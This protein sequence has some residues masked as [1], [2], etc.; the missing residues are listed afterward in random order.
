MKRSEDKLKNMDLSV[1]E[2]VGNG[3]RRNS[4]RMVSDSFLAIISSKASI[5]ELK[6]IADRKTNKED[7]MT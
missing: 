1:G 2:T 4:D 7:T 6:L 5:E 3:A